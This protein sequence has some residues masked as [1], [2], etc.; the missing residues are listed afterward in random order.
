[1]HAGQA[2]AAAAGHA[3]HAH[4]ATE[5]GIAGRNECGGIGQVGPGW[6]G[7]CR[8]GPAQSSGVA[9]ERCSSE[10]GEGLWGAAR[11]RCSDGPLN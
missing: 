9:E 1:M 5:A 3:L 8:A 4:L 7:P 2:R 11:P 10:A 6:E